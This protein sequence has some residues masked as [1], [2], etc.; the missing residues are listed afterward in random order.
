[1]QSPIWA[2]R[3]QRKD[4]LPKYK[5]NIAI[6]LHDF[7]EPRPNELQR[8]WFD[9]SLAHKISKY[10]LCA[11]IGNDYLH[12]TEPD[13]YLYQKIK[14]FMW[15]LQHDLYGFDLIE[16][17]FPWN[18]YGSRYANIHFTRRPFVISK[19]MRVNVELIRADI[20]Q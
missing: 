8:R 3:F 17:S 7:S 18:K 4:R 10:K 12:Q 5:I 13:F 1:M 16:H 14:E 20:N 11:K 19:I 9:L 6:L 2:Q 15:N